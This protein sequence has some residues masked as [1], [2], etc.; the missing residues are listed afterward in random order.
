MSKPALEE[1][2][3]AYKHQEVKGTS[4][5]SSSPLLQ[6]QN[7]EQ[8]VSASA[9][10]SIPPKKQLGNYAHS[11]RILMDLSLLA[12]EVYSSGTSEI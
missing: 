12:T 5:V 6:G 7:L 2:N 11:T 10:S 4:A 1:K 9:V 8:Y 3:S